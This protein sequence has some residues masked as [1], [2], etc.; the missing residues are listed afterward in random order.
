[1]PS[2]RSRGF[3]VF[4][5]SERRAVSIFSGGS[6]AIFGRILGRLLGAFS[7]QKFVGMGKIAFFGGVQDEM[8]SKTVFGAVFGRFLVGFRV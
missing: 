4:R 6:E 5:K 1:M 8:Q 2:K 7:V 3:V